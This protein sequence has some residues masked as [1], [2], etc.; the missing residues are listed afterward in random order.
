VT[1]AL[2]STATWYNYYS[3]MS[4]ASTADGEWITTALPDLEQAVF[5]R[6][7]TVLPILLHEDCV[8]LLPCMDRPIRLEIY[9]DA[10]GKASG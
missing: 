2:P 10:N 1:Y 5:V 7:G 8:S 6:G 9:P 4:V 3:K